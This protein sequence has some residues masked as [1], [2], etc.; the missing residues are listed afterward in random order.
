MLSGKIDIESFKVQLLALAKTNERCV[1]LQ[2][3][4]A[5]QTKIFAKNTF[6]KKTIFC[7]NKIK[8]NFQ[9]TLLNSCDF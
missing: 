2:N 3:L 7:K 5:E 8:T 6:C 1:T 9:L 4:N